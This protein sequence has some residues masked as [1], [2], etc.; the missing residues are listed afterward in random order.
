MS[1]K[2]A[3]GAAGVIAPATVSQAGA[4]SL[5]PQQRPVVPGQPGRLQKFEP[6]L[7]GGAAVV[8]FLVVWQLVAM[9]RVMPELFLPGPTDIATA[10]RSEFKDPDIW[11]DLATSGQ[12]LASGYGL[13]IAI[14]LPLGIL[15][16]WYRRFNLALDPFIS[17]F[18]STPRIAL[19][20]LLI[21]WFGIGIY[22]KIAVIFLGAFFPITINTMAGIR[23]L[24]TSLLKAARSFGAGD[25]QIFR[26][27][28][29]PGSVPFILTGLRLGVGHA[30]IGV[31]VGE[32]VAAQH[33]IGMRMA[34]AGE[35]FQTAKVFAD[36]ILIAGTG[37]V[38]TLILQRL[39][40]RFDAWRPAKG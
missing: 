30:L 31:V 29:L 33:G 25:A 21:I 14:G 37:V 9:A 28:A 12:E 27:I 1:A 26:T 13:A 32:L 23:S 4:T 15:L 8:F 39:E 24:D 19:L 11:L 6:L 5:P 2:R 20:P 36:L 17:F 22:S 16:G 35:T 34:I 40:R 3:A 10:F 7:I 38:L 18:Y